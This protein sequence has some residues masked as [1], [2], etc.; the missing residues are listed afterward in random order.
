[1]IDSKSKRTYPVELLWCSNPPGRGGRGLK[2]PLGWKFPV[3]VEKRLRADCAGSVL[4][5]FGGRSNWGTRIDIDPAVSPDVI[6]DAWLPP[7]R[8]ASFDTVILDPPY[9]RLNSQEKNALFRAAAVIARERV[10]WF[11]TIWAS[12]PPGFIPERAWVVRVGDSAH[13]RC[14]QYFLIRRRLGPVKRFL[15]GPAIKYNRWL[16]Q[17]H[18]LALSESTEPLS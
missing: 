9:T 6:A 11:H 14:L 12:T 1:M 5:L 16:G 8:E 7:F 10:V 18:G 3:A 2:N 15:R 17:P 13:V 4:H